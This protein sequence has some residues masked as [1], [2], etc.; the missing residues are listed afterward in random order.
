MSVVSK[1]L[2]SMILGTALLAIS[3]LMSK[4]NLIRA[5]FCIL[6]IIILTYSFS[7]ERTNKKLFVPLFIIIF[8]LFVIC[9]DYL[10]VGMFKKTPI[11]T[12][13]IVSSDSG[14][15]YNALGYRVWKCSDN[16]FKLDPLYKLGYYCDKKTMSSESINNVLDKLA[17]NIDDYKD[18]YVKI[19]GRVTGV[20]DEKTF[21]MSTFK[22]INNEIEYNEDYKL[23]VEFNVKSSNVYNLERD[24]VVTVLG[25]I[26][27]KE[28][29]N[30]YMN[31]AS[32][33]SDAQK[34]G[35][36]TLKAEVDSKCEFDKELWFEADETIYYRSCIQ[37]VNI[38]INNNQYSISDALKN[39]YISLDD[40]KNKSIGRLTN[41]SKD[42]S[43]LYKFQDFNMLVCDESYSKD[44]IIGKNTMSL[45]DGYCV[46]VSQGRGV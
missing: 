6:S 27:K 8:S 40:L 37:D 30:I 16:T 4:F 13:S 1:R 20:I 28:N 11:L 34:S 12:Y 25:R 2:I 22:E 39:K 10:V 15:V 7:L 45:D 23:I 46:N 24:S 36:V 21:Y 29:N 9:L 43:N 14:K 31:D 33:T 38:T 32:F 3:L 35:S 17:K 42:N 44:V 19:T 18:N 26:N 41:P 5:I